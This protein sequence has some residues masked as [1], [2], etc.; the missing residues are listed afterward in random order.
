MTANIF[1]DP[2]IVATPTDDT[3]RD[4]IIAWLHNL[5]LWLKEALSAHFLWLHARNITEQLEAHGCL[6]TFE[7][8]R[9]WVKRYRLDINPT[10][11]ARDINAFFRNP[12]HDLENKLVEFGYMETGD[13]ATIEPEQIMARWPEFIRTDMCNLLVT[14]SVCKQ[15]THLF[16]SNLHIVT[17]KL[18]DHRQEM[19]ISAVITGSISELACKPG[20]TITQT[21]PLLFTPENLQPLIDVRALWYKGETGVIYVIEQQFKKDWPQTVSQ[22]LKFTLGSHFLRSIEDRG[23][24]TNPSVL[25]K[26]VECAVYVISD[27]AKTERKY[28]YNLEEL[29]KNRSSNSPV[30]IRKSDRAEAWRLRITSHAAGWRLHYWYIPGPYGGAIEFS[31]ICKESDYT[32]YE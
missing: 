2:V 6:P 32:I 15:A 28:K 12:E 11:L 14:C 19:N 4:E 23:L 9:T 10:L 7:T 21:F 27:Q 3:D 13:P 1:V 18:S 29:R 5:E 20:N 16:A 30:K 22:A 17:L 25:S 31:N 24:D 8:L 26:I